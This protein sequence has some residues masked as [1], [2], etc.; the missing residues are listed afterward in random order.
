AKMKIRCQIE[1]EP[2]VAIWTRTQIMSVQPHVR[3]RH[4][5]IKLDAEV[6]VLYVVWQCEC[7]A[8]PSRPENRQR[9]GVGIQL[10][11]EWSLNRPIVRQAKLCPF[12]IIEAGL[13]CPFGFA[14]EEAPSVVKA[15]TSLIGNLHTA[16]SPD[17]GQRKQK[18]TYN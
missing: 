5:A 10:G 16:R 17:A 6:A 12:G 13:F 15:D 9:A 18:T 7:L 11:I 1:G 14:F 3:I 8:V 2:D 4:C